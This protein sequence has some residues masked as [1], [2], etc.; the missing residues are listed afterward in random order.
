[1]RRVS[2]ALATVRSD[3]LAHPTS[4]EPRNFSRPRDRGGEYEMSSDDYAVSLPRADGRCG[5]NLH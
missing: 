4:P 2:R 5:L 1:M 3:R